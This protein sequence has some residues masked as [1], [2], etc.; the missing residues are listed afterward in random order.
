MDV[1]GASI[2]YGFCM[3]LQKDLWGGK[4]F[5]FEVCKAF[6]KLF[7]SLVYTNTDPIMFSGSG[8]WRFL[9]YFWQCLRYLLK[10]MEDAFAYRYDKA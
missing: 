3:Q 6:K 9:R 5:W 7:L 8:F 10:E 2:L 4:V 1:G